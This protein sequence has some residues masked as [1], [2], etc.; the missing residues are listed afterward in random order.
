MKADLLPAWTWK[1]VL[2]IFLLRLGLGRLLAGL[3]LFLPGMSTIWVN[4]FDRLIMIFLV[5]YVVL[6]RYKSSIRNLGLQLRPLGKNLLAGLLTGFILL[7]LTK[8]IPSSDHPLIR[9]A[10]EAKTAKSFLLPLFLGG[11]LTPVAEEIFYRGFTYPALR[12]E[13]G[14]WWG[15]VSSSLFFALVHLNWRWF[16]EIALVGF[17]L[18]LLY[19]ITGSLLPGMIA[20][21]FLNLV[22]L[23]GVYLN[24]SGI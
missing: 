7:G 6:V 2:A 16:W 18:T 12:K 21:A 4:L 17:G 22:R 19:E 14:V 5:V 9:M 20:H 24:Y 1:T 10:Q 11:V 15:L 8:L 3:T 23:I 13:L